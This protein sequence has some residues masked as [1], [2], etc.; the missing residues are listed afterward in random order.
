[1]VPADNHAGTSLHSDQSRNSQ[2]AVESSHG[3]RAAIPSKPSRRQGDLSHTRHPRVI[4][5]LRQSRHQQRK[6]GD[7]LTGTLNQSAIATL[8]ER[9]T[10]YVMLVHLP[11]THTA[12]EVRD[13]LVATMSTLPAHLRGS[14]IFL[15]PRQPLAARV[16]R[17]HQRATPAVLPEGHRPD[18]LRHRRSRTR[19]AGTQQP[20]TQNARLGYPSRAFTEPATFYL[21][22][23]HVATTP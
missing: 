12:E 19:R 1:M 15:R 9:T 22:I 8:V 6:E 14:L 4:G 5:T 3:R 2:S 18:R 10:R 16:E 21:T 7:L 20:T 17:E 13:G 11:R 23:H